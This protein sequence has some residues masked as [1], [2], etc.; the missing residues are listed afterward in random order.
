MPKRQPHP[1]PTDL[2]TYTENCQSDF[3]DLIVWPKGTTP[4]FGSLFSSECL[5]PGVRLV[6]PGVDYGCDPIL[7]E[8]DG[9][10]GIIKFPGHRGKVWRG[11]WEWYPTVYEI[12]LIEAGAVGLVFARVTPGR[13]YRRCI[14]QLRILCWM[15]RATALWE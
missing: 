7:D 2:Q 8:R 1:T 10:M 3:P 15:L 6:T 11:F 5:E 4:I 12:R 9:P 13:R 14:R